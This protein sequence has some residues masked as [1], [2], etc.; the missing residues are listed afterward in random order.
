MATINITGSHLAVLRHQ[1]QGPERYDEEEGAISVEDLKI[2]YL[3]LHIE[4]GKIREVI[5]S[6]K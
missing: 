1:E 4:D 6:C 5:I 2:N 3:P